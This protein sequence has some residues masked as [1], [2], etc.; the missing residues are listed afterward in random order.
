MKP[1]VYLPT[2]ISPWSRADHSLNYPYLSFR[3]KVWAQFIQPYPFRRQQ[4]PFI[5]QRRF[6]YYHPSVHL[7]APRTSTNSYICRSI[8]SKCI[9][10]PLT[11]LRNLQIV[12]LKVSMAPTA[13]SVPRTNVLWSS[14]STN[15]PTLDQSHDFTL[16][17]FSGT[18]ISKDWAEL[19]NQWSS[20]WRL[21]G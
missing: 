3:K 7:Q 19:L 12:K 13:L 5:R 21:Y 17:A 11:H 4:R 1:H 9:Q 6:G 14:L 20:T 10:H 8:T 18:H 2:A 16:R 15:L